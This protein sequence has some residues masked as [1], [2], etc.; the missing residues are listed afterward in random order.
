MLNSYYASMPDRL[1]EQYRNTSRLKQKKFVD[2]LRAY[3]LDTYHCN[4]TMFVEEI[5]VGEDYK[6]EDLWNMLAESGKDP[7]ALADEVFADYYQEHRQRTVNG[8][9]MG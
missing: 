3:L 4:F 9:L 7:Y 5:C 6:D 1:W 2:D 8:G